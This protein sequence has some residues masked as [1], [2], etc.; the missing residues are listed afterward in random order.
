MHGL[1]AL[2]WKNTCQASAFVSVLLAGIAAQLLGTFQASE[3]SAGAKQFLLA[4]SYASIFINIAATFCSYIVLVH[5]G[6]LG[7]ESPPIQ[8]LEDT[9]KVGKYQEVMAVTLGPSSQW[10]PM[11]YLWLILFYLGISSLILAF[12]TYVL[13]DAA[14]PIA[15]FICVIVALTVAPT[16]YCIFVKPFLAEPAN[17]SRADT[18]QRGTPADQSRK[19]TSQRRTYTG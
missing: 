17:L 11:A 10:K 5:L 9:S 14:T 16:T 12:L 4:I 13:L 2:R 19:R 15:I 8:D 3:G 1:V 6:E 7:F 18:S